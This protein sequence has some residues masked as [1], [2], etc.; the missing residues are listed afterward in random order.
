MP[1]TDIAGS[2]PEFPAHSYSLLAHAEVQKVAD[3]VGVR[4]LHF[5]GFFGRVDFPGRDGR[6]GDADILVEPGG[7]PTLVDALVADGWSEVDH[8]V[9]GGAGHGQTLRHRDGSAEVDLHHYAQGMRSSWAEVFEDLWGERRE[10]DFV[11]PTVAAPSFLDHAI[12]LLADAVCDT[13][14]SQPR[15]VA[16][17]RA[18]LGELRA[19]Q[20]A[21]LAGRAERFGVLALIND[22]SLAALSKRE[23]MRQRLVLARHS[24][25]LRSLAVWGLRVNDEPT[26]AGKLKVFREALLWVPRDLSP[27]ER[28][29]YVRFRFGKAVRGLPL[30][31]SEVARAVTGHRSK[32]IADLTSP[33]DAYAGPASVPGVGCDGTLLPFPVEGTPGRGDGVIGRPPRAS[34]MV[35]RM[36][37]QTESECDWV[38]AE[39]ACGRGNA[40]Q[41]DCDNLVY[42]L[43]DEGAVFLNRVSRQVANLSGIGYLVWVAWLGGRRDLDDIVHLVVGEVGRVPAGLP[44][45][46]TEVVT[47]TVQDLRG[48]GLI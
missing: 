19:S 29:T 36:D 6:A 43:T 47:R 11:F 33:V 15:R 3:K 2:V 31:V 42:F 8:N 25:V 44:F 48:A 39:G 20:L 45:S 17:R 9:G 30:A 22:G 38:T 41:V 12:L 7:I 13:F 32:V 26:W 23:V 14:S 37:R 16:R 10:L 21:L 27:R 1:A 35:E 34:S 4:L 46:A 24:P 28:V 40:A 5:K 18:I